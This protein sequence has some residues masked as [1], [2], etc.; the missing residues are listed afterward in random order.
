MSAPGEI[1]LELLSALRSTTSQ[2][3][4]YTVPSPK[5]TRPAPDVARGL[6]TAAR[7]VV[8]ARTPEQLHRAMSVLRDAVQTYDRETSTGVGHF[9]RE[10]PCQ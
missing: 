3:T 2:V 6:A 4:D 10:G 8:N 7:L 9:T 5:L 1:S